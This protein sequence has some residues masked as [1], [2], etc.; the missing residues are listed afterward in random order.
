MCFFLIIAFFLQ[1]PASPG[2]SASSLTIVTATSS[3]SDSTNRWANVI[4]N[5]KLVKAMFSDNRRDA[6]TTKMT[7]R[8]QVSSHIIPA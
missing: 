6:V 4:W 8:Q 7:T 2:S 5:M 3:N 1:V